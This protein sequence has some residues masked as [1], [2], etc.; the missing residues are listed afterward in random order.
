M[1]LNEKEVFRSMI[2]FLDNYYNQL[3]S[4]DIAEL[5][6]KLTILI[7]DKSADQVMWNEWLEFVKVVK[8]EKEK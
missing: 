5:L 4:N 7:D 3:K 2:Y 8:N 6:K 1:E